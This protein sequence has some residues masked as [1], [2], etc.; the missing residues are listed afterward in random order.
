MVNKKHNPFY[1]AIIL[2]MALFFSL[3]AF[4]QTPGLGTW[5]VLNI[6]NNF[7]ERWNAFFEAQ[8]RSQ[9]FYYDFNY[10]EYKGGIGYNIAK[11]FNITL[12]AGQYVTYRPDGNFKTVTNSEFRLW[13]QFTLSNNL[14]RVKIEHRYRT[15]QRWL[16]AGYR[17]RFR[18][19]LNTVIPIN[20]QKVQ[21]KT[22]YAALFDEIFLSNERPYFERNR[23]F[24]GMGYMFT[25][26][27]TL[28][29]G[30]L[31]QLDISASGSK[32]NKHYLQVNLLFALNDAKS[33]RER[34]PSTAD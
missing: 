32:V 12:A 15:E 21:R 24:G 29:I 26:M 11:Q 1:K 18:Y 22:V 9:Q 28:Q 27:F 4:N 17:N 33:K 14:G 23:A 2:V 5:N 25:E 8:T 16:S 7:N 20:T 13:Q 34:H 6:K 19:R 10:H 3:Q 30:V 31:N